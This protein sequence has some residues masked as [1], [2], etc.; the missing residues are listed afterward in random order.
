MRYERTADREAYRSGRY[1]RRLVTG[2]GEVNLS[3]PKLCGAAER[4]VRDGFAESLAYTE[5]PP[6]HWRRIRMNNGIERINQE[7]RRRTRAVG[8]FPDGNSALILVTT[9]LKYIAEH[10]WDKRRYLDMSK[11]E[12]MDELRERRRARRGRGQ[13]RLNQFAKDY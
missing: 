11:L 13:G 3:V 4:T 8:T 2:A 6:E 10:E 1:A 9:R 5:F 7:I 12:E